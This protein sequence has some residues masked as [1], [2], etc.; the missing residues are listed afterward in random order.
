LHAGKPEIT[1]KYLDE[2]GKL[3]DGWLNMMQ[4]NMTQGDLKSMSAPDEDTEE[5]QSG[6]TRVMN[7]A[8]LY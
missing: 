3:D 6:T 8:E 4:A 1:D 5:N 2:N 7:L